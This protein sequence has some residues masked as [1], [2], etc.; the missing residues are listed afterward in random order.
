[1]IDVVWACFLHHA[2]IFRGFLAVITPDFSTPRAVAHSG[3]SGCKEKDKKKALP[4]AQ[5]TSLHSG[6]CIGDDCIVLHCRVV[7]IQTLN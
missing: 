7:V 4:V 6:T 2:A 3:G 1:M 5:T